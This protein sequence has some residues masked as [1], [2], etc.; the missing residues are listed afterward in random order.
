MRLGSLVRVSCSASCTSAEVRASRRL[1]STATTNAMASTLRVTAVTAI[2][3]QP[4]EMPVF[5]AMQMLSA[6]KPAAFMPV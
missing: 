2:A 5:A 4:A 1:S 6:G 3:S